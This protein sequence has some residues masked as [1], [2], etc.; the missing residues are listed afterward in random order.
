MA[1]FQQRTLRSD[2]QTRTLRC[3]QLEDR[4]MLAVVTVDTAL[5]VIDFNDGVTSLREAIFATNIVPGPDEIVFDFGHDGPEKIIL[6]QGELKITDS[7]IIMGSGAELLT[8]DVSGS[9]P[10]PDENNQDGSRIFNIDDG[11]AEHSIDVSISGMSLTGG[12]VQYDGGAIYS[13]GNITIEDAHFFSNHSGGDGGALSVDGTEAMLLRVHFS[14]NSSLYSGGAISAYGSFLTIDD[15]VIRHNHSSTYGG[16]VSVSS[17]S[18][19]LKGTDISENSAEGSGGGIYS[20]LAFLEITSSKIN[21]NISGDSG[22]GMYAVAGYHVIQDTEIV[23]NIAVSGGGGAS[24]VFGSM[25]LSHVKIQENVATQGGGIRAVHAGLQVVDSTITLNKSTQSGGGIWRQHFGNVSRDSSEGQD[26]TAAPR[27]LLANSTVSLNESMQDGGG[28]HLSG[29]AAT[30]VNSTLSG[31]KADGNGGGLYLATREG[32]SRI[33]H[34]TITNNYSNWDSSRGG[35]GGGMFIATGEV[36]LDHTLIAENIDGSGIAPDLTG[37]LGAVISPHFSLIGTNMGSGL[38]GAPVGSPDA[39]GN[40]I[41]ETGNAK[42]DPRLGPLA[43]NGGPTLTHALL[44]GSP[45]IDVGDSSLVQDSEGVSLFDQRGDGF[46]RTFFRIDIGAYE[47]N[48]L[49]ERELLVDTLVDESDNDFSLGDLSLREAIELANAH[50]GSDNIY[51]DWAIIAGTILLEQGE[52]LVTDDLSIESLPFAPIT[53]DASGNDPTPDENK[54]DGSRVFNID[55]GEEATNIY[56]SLVGLKL[57]GGDIA[58]YGGAVLSHESLF[59]NHIDVTDNSADF[60][61][62]IALFG[63][64]EG[65]SSI[66]FSSIKDNVASGGGGLYF[67]LVNSSEFAL[68]GNGIT[69]NSSPDGAGLHGYAS[70]ESRVTIRG[71]YI[72]NNRGE[73]F[74]VD[75]FTYVTGGGLRVGTGQ[76]ATMDILENTIAN[77]ST[78]G[79]LDFG[80]GI[81]GQSSGNSSL[82]IR[83]NRIL[84]NTAFVGGGAY[85]QASESSVMTISHNEISQNVASNVGGGF[86][87]SSIDLST[88]MFD[89]NSVQQNEGGGILVGPNNAEPMVIRASTITGNT[90]SRGAGISIDGGGVLVIES[91]T[92][93]GNTASLQGGGIMIDRLDNADITIR[94]STIHGNAAQD[95][96]GLFSRAGGKTELSIVSTTFSKNTAEENGGGIYMEQF[97]PELFK[98]AH[99]TV[100]NNRTDS[101]NNGSGSGGGLHLAF[102][103]LTLD[104]TI[105]A[106]NRGTDGVLDDVSGTFVN[107]F[108]LV[109]VP[110]GPLGPLADNGGPTLTHALLEGSLA[111]NA[112]NPNWQPGTDPGA[113]SDQR[114]MPFARVAN[115]QIDVGAYEQQTLVGSIAGDFDHDSDIDGSD[116]LVWQRGYGSQQRAQISEGNGNE[117]FNGNDLAVWQSNYGDG[118]AATSVLNDVENDSNLLNVEQSVEESVLPVVEAVDFVLTELFLGTEQSSARL[119]LTAARRNQYSGWTD[120]SSNSSPLVSCQNHRPESISAEWLEV[121]A[122]RAES[123]LTIEAATDAVFSGI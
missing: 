106:N 95:G 104:H 92:I 1:S 100:V 85:L 34:S 58:G 68:L 5:D 116:F 105:V 65:R 64:G 38:I 122:V 20:R 63:K 31:N 10:T 75:D 23:R 8:I 50:D 56:V 119:P 28:L 112:G 32:E 24:L 102:R 12:D 57:T 115:G 54:R 19:L 94:A 76:A 80:G 27:F 13:V 33:L 61:G 29:L 40:L 26:S 120:N 111:I 93:S 36:S 21:E 15:S 49:G 97:S 43:N 55:D 47:L 98:F 30:I 52:L 114:G 77:N 89:S 88:L 96:G 113:E 4:R 41:G 45:A 59:L 123:S 62:G 87:I 17:R 121:E 109:G 81:Y 37:F 79:T 117:K 118:L 9:D 90:A 48:E 107:H 66:V 7:L 18:L 16:G 11:D 25:D 44:P 99:N 22:G 103:T 46:T 73:S 83:G 3:E 2:R 42:I 35:A 84:E 14:E 108:S 110:V 74:V 39:N 51:F 91:T 72:L 6:T 60:G 69:E 78:V 53:I 71:N 86:A 67:N 101:D 82:T 70:G